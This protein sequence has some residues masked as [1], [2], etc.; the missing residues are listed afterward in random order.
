MELNLLCRRKRRFRRE[1]DAPRHD[2]TPSC[3]AILKWVDDFSVCDSVVNTS[4][5]PALFSRTPENAEQVTAE[6]L[7]S[8]T[9]SDRRHTVAFKI[10]SRS[11]Q[12][13]LHEDLR[14]H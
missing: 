1:F 7:E 10:L 11:L 5:R 4:V 3:K 2:R 8:R 14:F 6:I 12:R 13:I 9:R